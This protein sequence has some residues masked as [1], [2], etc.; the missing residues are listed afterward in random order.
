MKIL[1]IALF[2]FNA[3]LSESQNV[4]KFFYISIGPARDGSGVVLFLRDQHPMLTDDM[5][6]AN[7]CELED[8]FEYWPRLFSETS[9][10]IISGKASGKRKS[11]ENDSLMYSNGKNSSDSVKPKSIFDENLCDSYVL[12]NKQT[13]LGIHN[14][15]ATTTTVNMKHN[16]KVLHVYGGHCYMKLEKLT[17]PVYIAVEKNG[18]EIFEATLNYKTVIKSRTNFTVGQ[19]KP[20]P[21]MTYGSNTSTD[22]EHN[23]L[24]M[25]SG[26]GSILDQINNAQQAVNSGDVST[27]NLE[28]GE[29]VL[30]FPEDERKFSRYK[31]PYSKMA[32]SHGQANEIDVK[33][34]QCAKNTNDLKILSAEMMLQFKRPIGQIRLDNPARQYI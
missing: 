30:H 24:S 16:C 12:E 5:N 28:V 7:A 6:E 17:E 27:D 13:Q 4:N 10:Y 1:F 32:V 20:M 33:Y 23:N 18:S 25:S 11:P 8:N 29:C 22:D 31:F 21:T 9:D 3:V 14:R 2:L 26:D 34:E 15:K 19:L